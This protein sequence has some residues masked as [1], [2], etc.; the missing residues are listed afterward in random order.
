MCCLQQCIT[1]FDL[2]KGAFVQRSSIFCTKPFK[3]SLDLFIVCR[4]YTRKLS[5]HNKLI[6]LGIKEIAMG[7]HT[8]FGPYSSLFLLLRFASKVLFFR[9]QFQIH[10]FV[11]VVLCFFS[12]LIWSWSFSLCFTSSCYN[13][14]SVFALLPP[15]NFNKSYKLYLCIIHHVNM[16][17]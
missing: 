12:F 2:H 11:V 17:I 16:F 3:N 9:F 1:I 14:R 4:K 6:G 13:V 7:S 8:N 15:Y 10:L 5:M